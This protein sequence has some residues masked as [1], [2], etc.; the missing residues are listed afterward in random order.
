VGVRVAAGLCCRSGAAGC[1]VG[2]TAT[3][4]DPVGQGVGR[5]P[6]FGAALEAVIEAPTTPGGVIAFL[7]SGGRRCESS[8]VSAVFDSHP[9]LPHPILVREWSVQRE[10]L[11][12]PFQLE[13]AKGAYVSPSSGAI[14][15]VEQPPPRATFNARLC[16]HFV[17]Q[18]RRRYISA[19]EH[20]GIH[21]TKSQ[22]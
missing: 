16:W 6:R 10:A 21:L 9:D 8:V 4:R 14:L 22:L 2:T 5:R 18:L 11:C 7:H 15:Y 19:C 17:T 3:A 12:H 13:C 1:R 20:L